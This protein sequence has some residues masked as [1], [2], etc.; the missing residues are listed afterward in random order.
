MCC[1]ATVLG[2]HLS[3]R[4]F[5]CAFQNDIDDLLDMIGDGIEEPAAAVHPRSTLAKDTS[6]SSVLSSR[7][8]FHTGGKKK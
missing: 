8:E 2:A 6:K 1:P 5:Y 3:L 7:E 4:A